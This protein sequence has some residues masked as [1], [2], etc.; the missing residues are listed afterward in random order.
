MVTYQ[1][2]SQKLAGGPSFQRVSF[3]TT[4]GVASVF[5]IGIQRSVF[6]TDIWFGGGSFSG[7]FTQPNSATT[8]A[9]HRWGEEGDDPKKIGCFPKVQKTFSWSRKV[10]PEP[11]SATKNVTWRSSQ[12]T[13]L[14]AR[15]VHS[16]VV[17]ESYLVLSEKL[18][19]IKIYL[20]CHQVSVDLKA[21]QVEQDLPAKGMGAR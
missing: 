19:V 8:A 12:Q 17:M 15:R 14:Q 2:P 9:S 16:G 10:K 4:F 5:P 3:S 21:S 11:S 6:A 18:V 7:C 13:T 1:Y 20:S